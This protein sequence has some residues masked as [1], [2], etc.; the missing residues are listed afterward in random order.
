MDEPRVRRDPSM[1]PFCFGPI[2]DSLLGGGRCTSCGAGPGD[3][4]KPYPK[5]CEPDSPEKRARKAAAEAKKSA[6]GRAKA[7]R[8]RKARQKARRR[9]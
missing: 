3:T 9:S 2:D 5:G 1:C 6:R 4:G 7:K 8:A